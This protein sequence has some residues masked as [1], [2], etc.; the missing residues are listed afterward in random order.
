MDFLDPESPSFDPN[1]AFLKGGH[2][3]FLHF[4]AV[5]E[6]FQLGFPSR[7]DSKAQR[8]LIPQMVLLFAL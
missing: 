2:F 1:N 8:P 6:I 7:I 5:L 4:M 3:V